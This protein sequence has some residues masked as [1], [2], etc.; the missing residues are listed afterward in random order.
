MIQKEPHQDLGVF[1][2][3]VQ[4]VPMTGFYRTC[5]L[6]YE[7]QITGLYKSYDSDIPRSQ[8]SPEYSSRTAF[9]KLGC[10]SVLEMELAHQGL[11]EIRLYQ[12]K[13]NPHQDL[14]SRAMDCKTY[15]TWT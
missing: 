3:G 9:S 12:A 13:K 10:L 6:K 1:L 2:R 7:P 5:M 15:Q 14:R 4:P 8:V 11:P